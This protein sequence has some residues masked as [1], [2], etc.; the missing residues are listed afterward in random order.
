MTM[1]TPSYL[2]ETI[3][4][5]SLH[6]CRS[7]LEDPTGQNGTEQKHQLSRHRCYQ[8]AAPLTLSRRRRLSPAART[9]HPGVP[10]Q[11][12]SCVTHPSLAAYDP[13]ELAN[14]TASS[15]V[16]FGE[17]PKPTREPRALP[18]LRPRLQAAHSANM[19]QE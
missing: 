8:P 19:F 11:P 17:P 5:S 9:E 4:Y 16:H 1:I 7:T 6:A 2:G 3:E 12:N 13:N 18:S 14:L 10:T 15:E